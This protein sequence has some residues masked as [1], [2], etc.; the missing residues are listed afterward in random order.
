MSKFPQFDDDVLE[1]IARILENEVTQAGLNEVF[2]NCGI[3]DTSGGAKWRRIFHSLR[4]RQVNDFCGNCVAHLIQTI[5]K[6]VKYLNKEDHFLTVIQEL[7][8]VL[9]FSGLKYDEEGNFR[10]VSMAKTISDAERRSGKLR[11]K[12]KERRIHSE[13]IKYSSKEYLEDNYFHAVFEAVKGLAQRIRNLSGI[14]KDGVELL[15]VAFSTKQPL[16]AINALQTDTDRSEHNGLVWL[17]KGCFS[18]IRNPHAHIPKVLW[19]ETEEDAAD[20]LTLISLLHFKLD[21][22]IVVPTNKG[23]KI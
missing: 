4:K 13:V 10:K 3:E 22:V 11:H 15:E 12:L 6:P 23:D 17:L 18:G 9:S 21:R 19:Q 7:N 14:N 8:S 2:L 5:L 1:K 20:Y 16:L